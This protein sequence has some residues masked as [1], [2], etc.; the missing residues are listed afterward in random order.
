[1]LGDE[2]APV[3]PLLFFCGKIQNEFDNSNAD[4]FAQ[5]AL[6]PESA[7]IFN[8]FMDQ[9]MGCVIPEDELDKHYETFINKDKTDL[10][11]KNKLIDLYSI[12]KN[13][14]NAEKK[15]LAQWALTYF[16]DEE[17]IIHDDIAVLGLVDDS[18]V[19][20]FALKILQTI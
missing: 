20:D 12:L 13:D 14:T 17:D 7:D 8:A 9:I 10:Q 18:M 16:F 15:V 5:L 19:I 3:R 1:M 6:K 2:I 11:I 4:A